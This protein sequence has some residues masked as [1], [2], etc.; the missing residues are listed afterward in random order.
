[1][2]IFPICISRDFQTVPADQEQGTR[3]LARIDRISKNL[4]QVT[5]LAL[6]EHAGERNVEHE[7][8]VLAYQTRH[9]YLSVVIRRILKIRWRHIRLLL[10]YLVN[11][12]R[13]LMGNPSS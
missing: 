13:R 8:R 4:D 6:W 9:A 7:L 3:I 2:R 5:G 1:M 11:K 10:G 12:T